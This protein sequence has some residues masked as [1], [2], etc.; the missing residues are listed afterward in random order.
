[1]EYFLMFSYPL[2]FFLIEY[3]TIPLYVK[4]NK[5]LFW[6]LYSDKIIKEISKNYE[7]LVDDE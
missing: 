4:H 5:E 7:R 3:F 1:M 2:V 6:S